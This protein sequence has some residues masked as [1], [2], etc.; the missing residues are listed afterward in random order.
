VF[1]EGIWDERLEYLAE[2]PKGKTIGMFQSS[3]IFKVKEGSGD[4][5]CIYGGMPD[6]LLTSGSVQKVRERT[7]KVCEVVS[8]GGGFVMTTEVG[9]MEGSKPG[10]VQAWVNTTKEYRVYES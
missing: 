4:T 3:D 5:M 8:K 1:Y 10:L 9:E 6:S 7:H 2:S